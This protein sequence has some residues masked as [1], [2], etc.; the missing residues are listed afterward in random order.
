MPI[1]AHNPDTV[2]G[3]AR[4]RGVLVL[5]SAGVGAAKTFDFD[6]DVM[7]RLIDRD[8]VEVAAVYVVFTASATVGTRQIAC[9]FLDTGAVLLAR[10]AAAGTI[11]V[12][13]SKSILFGGG[14]AAAA[15]IAGLSL[16]EEP[17]PIGLVLGNGMQL[18]VWDVA[19]ISGT[20]QL[21]AYVHL[22]CM[23]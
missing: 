23:A 22:R 15:G 3:A 1:V 16:N 13:Q 5:S 14:L 10:C 9:D 18:K 7:P 20:D 4:R 21:D 11:I 19:G 2:L 12:S 6:A 17:L 8:F